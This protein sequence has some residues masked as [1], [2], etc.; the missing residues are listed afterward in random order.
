MKLYELWKSKTIFHSCSLFLLICI[1]LHLTISTSHHPLACVIQI[2]EHP[3]ATICYHLQ[4]KPLHLFPGL[5]LCLSISLSLIHTH[6]HVNLQLLIAMLNLTL[7]LSLLDRW[8]PLW[9]WSSRSE[10]SSIAEPISLTCWLSK[11]P[12]I[13]NLEANQLQTS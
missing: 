10:H 7:L 1:S 8:T 5:S 3:L 11:H 6:R 4:Q 9:C 12:N 2:Y 13:T